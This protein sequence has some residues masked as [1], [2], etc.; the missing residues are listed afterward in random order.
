MI[1]KHRI[2]ICASLIALSASLTVSLPAYSQNADIRVARFLDNRSGAVSYTF[3]DGL[4]EQ[5]TE[6]FPVLQQLGLKCSFCVNGN[7]IN[8]AKPTDEKPRMTWEMIKEMSDKGQEISS[9][10]WT[11][12]NIKKIHGEALRYEVQHN[13]TVIWQ[14]TGVFPRTYF[15]PG[16]SKCEEGIA[17]ASRDR[18]GTRTFQISLGSKRDSLWLHNWI[19]SVI[20]NK[21]WA[22]GMTHGI[23]RGYDHFSNPQVFFNHLKDAC[24]LQDSLWIGTFHDVAAYVAE[25]DT[26][27]LKISYSNRKRKATIKP[28]IKLDKQIFTIPLTLLIP[29]NTK[30]VTQAGKSLEIADYSGGKMVNIN[31]FGGKIALLFE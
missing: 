2:F 26:I 22:V 7:T 11:H 14:H 24:H 27:Q 25:R 20:A 4:L 10:G 5:Y 3:D 9:H 15:Y 19:R 29:E 23:S 18:V 6:L 13:D 8:H 28:I 12:T 21:E 30:A 31:P 1:C 16:N 17:Y